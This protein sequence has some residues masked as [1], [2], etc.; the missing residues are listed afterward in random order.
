MGGLGTHECML[1]DCVWEQNCSSC[2]LVVGMVYKGLH[3][4][5][6]SGVRFE[7]SDEKMGLGSLTA[8]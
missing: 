4:C 3:P 7:P 2:V 1:F 6:I 8:F 5:G